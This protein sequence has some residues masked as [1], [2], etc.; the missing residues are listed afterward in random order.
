MMGLRGGSAYSI[1]RPLV[2]P[3]IGTS[4]LYIENIV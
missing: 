4:D 1:D 2:W 3:G